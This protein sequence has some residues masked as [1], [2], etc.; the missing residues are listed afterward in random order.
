MTDAD[1]RTI[2]VTGST[3]GLGRYLVGQLAR[4]GTHV[5][6]HGRAA[7]KVDRVVADLAHAGQP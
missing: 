4:P 7:A 2:L 6:V 5:V 1:L 3:A